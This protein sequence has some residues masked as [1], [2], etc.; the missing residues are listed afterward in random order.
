[1]APNRQVPADGIMTSD[2]GFAEFDE[3]L[4]TGNLAECQNGIDRFSV[5]MVHR[6]GGCITT[7]SLSLFS[8]ERIC[9]TER[10]EHMVTHEFPP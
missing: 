1:M 6:R 2:C 9:W 7:P 8:L 3:S 4:L 5:A 10:I